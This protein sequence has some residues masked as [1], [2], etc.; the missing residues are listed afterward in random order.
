VGFAELPPEH[1]YFGGNETHGEAAGAFAG[2]ALAQRISP[3]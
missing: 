2:R 3:R 1:T